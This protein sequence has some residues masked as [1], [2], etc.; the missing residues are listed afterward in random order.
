MILLDVL[1]LTVLPLQLFLVEQALILIIGRQ[2]VAQLLQAIHWLVELIQS[3]Q[4]M[5]I[6]ALLVAP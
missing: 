1:L 3:L 6:L 2:Q 4:L 5:Q